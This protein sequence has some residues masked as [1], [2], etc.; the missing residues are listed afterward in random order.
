[1]NLKKLIAGAAAFCILTST[2]AA[3]RPSAIVYAEESAE[4][5]YE[6]LP[7]PVPEPIPEPEP[8]PEP[9]PVP[10]P[11]AE[12]EPE[13]EPMPEPIPE[14]VPEPEEDWDAWEEWEDWDDSYQESFEEAPVPVPVPGES[15][16]YEDFTDSGEFVPSEYEEAPSGDYGS[17]SLYVI[18]N[19]Y[20]HFGDAEELIPLGKPIFLYDYNVTEIEGYSIE[21]LQEQVL[22]VLGPGLTTRTSSTSPYMTPAAKA[23]KTRFSSGP[24]PKRPLLC[25]SVRWMK[26]STPTKRTIWRW[27][28]RSRPTI[29]LPTSPATP[30]S[31]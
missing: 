23:R 25:R 8:E 21:Y 13:P 28:F 19:G 30:P 27:N 31:A 16:F 11:E 4:E 15:D 17:G 24:V 6:Q 3:G 29:I 5:V 7:E 12:P 14:P 18:E 2:L 26:C 22:F 1:M 20:R 10:E 9:E